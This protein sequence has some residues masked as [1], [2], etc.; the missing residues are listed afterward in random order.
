MNKNNIA[1]PVVRPYAE[2][3]ITLQ[4]TFSVHIQTVTPSAV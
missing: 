1:G 2:D 3:L 4:V